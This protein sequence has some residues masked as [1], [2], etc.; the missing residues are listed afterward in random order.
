MREQTAERRAINALTPDADD[1]ADRTRLARRQE[2]AVVRERVAEATVELRSA[3]LDQSQQSIELIEIRLEVIRESINQIQPR[4]RFTQDDLDQRLARIADLQDRLTESFDSIRSQSADL[5]GRLNQWTNERGADTA[6]TDPRVEIAREIL[7][8]LGSRSE[9]IGERRRRTGVRRD[10]WTDRFA[11]QRGEYS[12]REINALKDDVEAIRRGLDADE[13]A[14]T[15]RARQVRSRLI[16]LEGELATIAPGTSELAVERI[17]AYRALAADIDGALEGVEVIRRNYTKL[18]DLI[19]E[20]AGISW[21]DRVVIAW[22]FLTKIWSYEIIELDDNTALTVDKLVIGLF[23]LA[24]AFNLSRWLA[25]LLSARVLP[26]FGLNTH[27]ASAFKNHP[28]LHPASDLRAHGVAHHRSAVDHLRRSRRCGGD[29]YWLRFPDDRQQF[30]VRA[31]PAGRTPG[32]RRRLHRR[33]RRGRHRSADRRTLDSDQDADQHRDDPA[34][35]HAPRQQSGELDAHRSG[36]VA[37]RRGRY[38][39]RLADA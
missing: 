21:W 38:R 23:L 9:V 12:G 37:R 10:G 36:G 16:T 35:L 28:L 22:S 25:S 27:A 11:I 13:S 29:R 19:G 20:R 14:L 7:I 24:V 18:A 15:D 17:D 1:R 5:R 4:V 8:V 34:Q 2:L 32:P 6:A 3:Q 39:L 33:Q 31:H 26:R 30:H